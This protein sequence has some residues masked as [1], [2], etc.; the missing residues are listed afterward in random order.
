MIRL[1]FAP[2]LFGPFIVSVQVGAVAYEEQSPVQPTNDEPPSATA[3]SVTNVPVAYGAEHLLPQMIPGWTLETIPE[4]L[5]GL[6][7]VTMNPFK[8]TIADWAKLFF[9]SGS[10]AYPPFETEPLT[11][12]VPEPGAF[13]CTSTA[14]LWSSPMLDHRQRTWRSVA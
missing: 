8:T 7:T 2:T 5:P 13:T 11:S 12:S 6:P 1:K 3:V 4:P 9:G 10:L 14:T